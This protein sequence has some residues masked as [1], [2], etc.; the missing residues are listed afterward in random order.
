MREDEIKKL[1]LQFFEQK[2][3]YLRREVKLGHSFIDFLMER[4]EKLMGIEVKSENSSEFHA[5]G[6]LLSYYKYLSHVFLAA[7]LPFLLKFWRLLRKN[8][9]L[10]RI[11]Y[12]LGI[13]GI[14]KNEVSFQKEAVNE[15]YYFNSPRILTHQSRQLKKQ[16]P[17]LDTIDEKILEIIKE[18]KRVILHEISKTLGMRIEATRKRIHNLEQYKFL[19]II[20]RTPT[21]I[22]LQDG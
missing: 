14:F 15:K 10:E 17:E 9:E 18:N 2:G 4:D 7:P 5:L 8:P 13:I 11:S 19:K 16:I 6:Q 3:T 12:K 22:T 21:V 20:S 1:I